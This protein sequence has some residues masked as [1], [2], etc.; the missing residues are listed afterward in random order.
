MKRALVS[1]A[2]LAMLGVG[3]CSSD[4]NPTLPPGTPPIDGGQGDRGA[5]L[6]PD[7]RPPALEVGDADASSVGRR[8]AAGDMSLAG[9]GVAGALDVAPP[10]IVKVAILAPAAGAGVDGGG[11]A[12]VVIAAADRLAPTVRVEVQSQ[13]GDPTLDVIEQVKAELLDEEGKGAVSAVLNQTQYE[14]VSESATKISF[15][16]DTPVD[17]SKVNGGFYDLRVTAATAGGVIASAELPV[18][19]DCGPVISFLRP[20]DGVFVK[21]SLVVTAI[22]TDSRSQLVLVEISVG[23]VKL[24][25]S[26]VLSNGAQY[27]VTLDFG[28]FNPP[29]DG[30]QTVTVTAQ[31]ANGNVS[32]ATRRFTVDNEGPAITGTK[33]AMGELIGTLIPLQAQ[34]TDPAGV[35]EGSV[36]AVVA[37]GDVEFKVKL[38]KGS[39]NSYSQV[40]DTTQLPVYT[41]FPSISFR[42]QDTLGNQSSVGYLV[43]LDNTPP[44]LDLD[45]PDN[46]RLV[47]QDGTCSWPFDPVGPD[48]IDDGSLVNQLFDIR[49]RI[50]DDGNTPLTGVV[51]FVPIG[52]VDAKT[53][54]VLILDETSLPLVVD[55][56]NPPDGFC[57]DINPELQ[58]SVAPV[59]SK[60]TQLMDMVSMPANAG[61][62]DFSYQPGVSC[63]GFSNPPGPLCPTTYSEQKDRVMTYALSYAASSLPSIWTIPPIV[64]DG[65]QCAGRQFDASN[66]LHD[67][68]ACVAVV[69]SDTLGNKQV[70]RP[71][72]ICVAAKPDST[73]CTATDSGGA[74]L[75]SVQL[76][77]SVSGGVLVTTKTALVGVGGSPIAQGD[78]LVFTGVMPSVVGFLNG[79]HQVEPQGGTGTQFVLSALTMAPLDL[80]LDP[81]DGTAPVPKGTVGLLVQ[82]GAEIQVIT[83]SPNTQLAADYAGAV[84]LLSR[85][86]E[87]DTG[88]KRWIPTNIQATGFSLDGW[89]VDLTGF[90]TPEAKLPNCTGTVVKDPAGGPALVDGTIP[91][92]PWSLFPEHEIKVLK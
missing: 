56:S 11:A 87:V 53:V 61:A 34:V 62:G 5:T 78:T 52:G 60:E 72:R 18:Y 75:A 77:S 89:T 51:D 46:F 82:D 90:A 66:N 68:W 12:A 23:Q 92:R 14:V 47:K 21:G 17:L 59:S 83:D 3:A 31:N 71:I 15:Y 27:T 25:P 20:A 9:D 6:P 7:T 43:S 65:L 22:V 63:T 32:L 70:S 36:I 33:P 91:C 40:F 48:A 24:D 80:W 88:T 44:T 39:G 79:S 54:K 29:L 84:I 30:P 19:V 4:A 2:A 37:H 1:C 67:G 45:P 41:I 28:S 64:G 26:V 73:A 35:M 86:E 10:S 55:T 85:G 58:P 8:D 38:D 16:G 50:E 69:A 42:A 76:P 57:D 13:G 81:L 49:A 74:D